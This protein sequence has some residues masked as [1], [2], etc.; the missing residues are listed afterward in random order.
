MDSTSAS[1]FDGLLAPVT[2]P[3]TYRNIAFLLVRL[4][5]GVAYFTVFVTG[6]ALGASLV[7]LIVGIP[8]LGVVLGFG[9]YVGVFEANV[10]NRFLNTDLDYTPAHDPREEPLVPYVKATLTDPRSY[11]LVGYFLVSMFVGIGTFTFVVVVFTLGLALA[12]A[13]IAHPLPFTQYESP[14]IEWAGDTV[15]IDTLPEALAASAVG[16]VLLFVGLYASNA[17]AAGH[18]RI[19]AAV[20]DDR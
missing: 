20:L 8:I 15:V 5:I 6:L 2:D 9:S 1:G 19:T 3:Q 10:L 14:Q 13:P 17:L 7:P 12:V 11:V 4:P 16:V 18:A